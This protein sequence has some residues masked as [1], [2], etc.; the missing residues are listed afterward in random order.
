MLIQAGVANGYA[1]RFLGAI[2]HAQDK[3]KEV[4][5]IIPRKWK[6]GNELERSSVFLDDAVRR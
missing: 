3:R 4:I 2:S 5:E 1:A 6:N